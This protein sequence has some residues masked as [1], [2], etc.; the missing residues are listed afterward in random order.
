MM[1]RLHNTE[2]HKNKE[3]ELKYRE[4]VRKLFKEIDDRNISNDKR[5][6]VYRNNYNNFK[7][8]AADNLRPK[9]L[10]SDIY[11]AI[12][13]PDYYKTDAKKFIAEYNNKLGSDPN[14]DEVENFRRY[15]IDRMI[16]SVKAPT[17]ASIV[18]RGKK[19]GNAKGL[20]RQKLSKSLKDLF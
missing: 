1:Q 5:L 7:K 9:T 20:G 17:K 19:S 3:F 16:R 6:F 12:G 13:G 2:T 4:T 8:L 15:A 10:Y 14:R 11:D 18:N